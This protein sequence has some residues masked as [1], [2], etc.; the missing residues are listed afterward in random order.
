MALSTQCG[1]FEHLLMPFGL[2]NVLAVFQEFVNN[3]YWDPLYI[4]EVVYLD[5]ILVFSP[6]LSLH[7]AQTVLKHLQENQLYAKLEKYPFEQSCL[8]FLG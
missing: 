6:Y 4:F 5:D 2:S 7:H 3:M 1:H 8:P